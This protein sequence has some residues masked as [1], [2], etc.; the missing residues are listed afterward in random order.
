MYVKFLI[1]NLVVLFI[2]G[3]FKRILLNMLGHKMEKGSK[4][5][6]SIV[7]GNT[8]LLLK[9]GASIGHFNLLN[10]N[11]FFVGENSRV[12][13][14]NIFRGFFHIR[15]STKSAIGNCNNF[16]NGGKGFVFQCPTF[17]I[18]SH[19][20]ITSTHYLDLTSSIILRRNVVVGGRGTQVWTHGFQHFDNGVERFRVDGGVLIEDGVYLGARVTIN[21]GVII[22]KN[23][24]VGAGAIVSKNL[25]ENSMYVSQ[26][27]RVLEKDKAK[28]LDNYSQVSIGNAALKAFVRK[29]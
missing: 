17:T 25:V 20:N 28:F 21:P 22:A 6:F 12:G 15:C 16:V 14:L 11:R 10:C 19:S 24:S 4:L 23:V 26:A 18:G 27:L 29:I 9:G 2:P 1:T 5:G 3:F 13:H 7:C 8:Q